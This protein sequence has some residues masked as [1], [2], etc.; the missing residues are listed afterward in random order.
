MGWGTK[1]LRVSC[2]FLLFTGIF[3]TAYAD[4]VL[5]SAAPDQDEIQSFYVKR[6]GRIRN[7]TATSKLPLD[8]ADP[9]IYSPKSVRFSAD[10]RKFYINS[11]EGGKTVVYS[12]PEIEKLKVIDHR[13]DDRHAHLFNGEETIFDYRYYAKPA[14]G[15]VN[16]FMGKPVES[17]LSHGGRYLWVP[18]YRRSYDP[19][20]QSPS[21][22]AIIDTDRDEI[23]RV[24]PTG[25]LPKYV[26]ISPNGRYA[27]I[28]HWGD[29]TVALIDIS[30]SSPQNFRYVAHISIE[31]KLSMASLVGTDRDKNCGY[32]L[33]GAVF[34]YDSA[35]LLVARMGGGG[36]A[37]IDI[38]RQQYM[39]SVMN[40]PPTPRHL[41]LSPDGETLFVSSNQSGVLSEISV[42]ALISALRDANGKRNHAPILSRSVNLGAGARTVDISPDGRIAFVALNNL[43]KIAMVSTYS[44]RTLGTI[45]ADPYPVGLAVSP[46]NTGF[47]TTSQG[48][49][50]VGGN[51][52]DIYAYGYEL[53]PSVQ[54]LPSSLMKP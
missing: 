51:A 33:R 26:A 2:I 7:F 5:H 17:E 10:G 52:V 28:I 21:A 6:I 29:N 27:A 9:D 45:E 42:S 50:G 36:I 23:V 43:S 48:R 20:A 11:L 44:F 19:S 30:S 12:W 13:F 41:V 53:M 25:P 35:Y 14:N 16:T 38:A 4:G 15:K 37:G 49:N 54:Q 1:T 24:M 40:V 39:G 8:L 3:N 46:D 22:V 32:C 34:T 18:Y 47:I 31:A